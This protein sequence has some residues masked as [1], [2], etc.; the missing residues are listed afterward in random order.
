MTVTVGEI[1]TNEVFA[2][3][4]ETSLLT[5]ARLF[6]GRHISGAPVVDRSGKTVG[7]IT[8]T[9]LVDPDR[10]RTARLGKSIFYRITGQASVTYGDDAV[11][12]DGIVA[13]VMSPFVL[14][15]SPDAPALDAARLMVTEDVHRLLVLDRG[16]LVGIVTSIDVLKA[17]TGW[18]RSRLGR[19]LR[20]AGDE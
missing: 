18:S 20:H 16:K 15:I 14:A 11:T 17:L 3:A 7:V 12:P 4:P 2:V 9:D 8:Q 6:A 13:D 1:M 19:E 10:D 5:C